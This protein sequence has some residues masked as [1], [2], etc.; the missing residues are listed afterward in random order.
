M[1]IIQLQNSASAALFSSPDDR[2]SKGQR[3][4]KKEIES[5][6]DDEAPLRKNKVGGKCELDEP[7]IIREF[8]VRIR[9]ALDA[10]GLKCEEIRLDFDVRGPENVMGRMEILILFY[11]HPIANRMRVSSWHN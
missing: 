6:S 1:K 5:E 4:V 2:R 9:C 3:K 11:P 8:L 7:G 10:P